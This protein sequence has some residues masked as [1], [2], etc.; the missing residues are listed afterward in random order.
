[1]DMSNSYIWRPA[2][3][4]SSTAKR[5]DSGSFVRGLK[6][7]DKGQNGGWWNV[8]HGLGPRRHRNTGI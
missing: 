6:G 3:S 5:L 8:V 2:K 1:M 4:D 7:T